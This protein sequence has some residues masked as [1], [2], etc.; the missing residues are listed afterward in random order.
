M[1]RIF[2]TYARTRLWTLLL[3]I[4]ISLLRGKLFLLLGTVKLLVSSFAKDEDYVVGTTFKLI[5]GRH[6]VGVRVTSVSI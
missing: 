6:Q 5:W 3:R 1:T 2:W 4:I